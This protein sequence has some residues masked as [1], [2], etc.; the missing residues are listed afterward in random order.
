MSAAVTQVS[1]N[2]T[3]QLAADLTVLQRKW[4]AAIQ[5]GQSLP[6]YEEVAED[7]IAF[8]RMTK[9]AHHAMQLK[10]HSRRSS[11]KKKNFR[12]AVRS[13]VAS[14]RLIFSLVIW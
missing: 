7:P 8:C 10:R 6:S 2:S 12:Y 13:L 11:D 14:I 1:E 9:L 3:S 4:H 5:P